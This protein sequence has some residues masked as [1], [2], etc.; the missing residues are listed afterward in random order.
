MATT[1]AQRFPKVFSFPPVYTPLLLFRRGCFA[2]GDAD[3]ATIVTWRARPP[4]R[5]VLGGDELFPL[6]IF[7]RF[8]MRSQLLDIRYLLHIRG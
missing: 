2:L 4:F 1:A 7:H 6:S 8:A 3:V 5:A